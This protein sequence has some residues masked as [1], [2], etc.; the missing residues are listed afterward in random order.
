M[1]RSRKS[2]LSLSKGRS[3]ITNGHAV[4][5]GV[6]HRIRSMRR[7]KDLLA[8]TIAD[9]GGVDLLSQGQLA[10]SRKAGMLILQ[11]EMME[12]SWNGGQASIKQ[13]ETYQR[14]VNT[15]RRCIETLGLHLGRRPRE[16]NPYEDPAWQ[17]YER[18][19]AR[20]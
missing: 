2:Q 5:A 9:L 7:L 1:A 14:T 4:L 12:A 11:T 15:L 16:I 17:A 6:D 19:M 13:L 18:E 3:A 10:L 20:P 8:A